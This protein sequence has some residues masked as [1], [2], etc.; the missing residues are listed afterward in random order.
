VEPDNQNRNTCGNSTARAKVT[1]HGVCGVVKI[2]KMQKPG[3]SVAVLRPS[4]GG[5]VPAHAVSVMRRDWRSFPGARFWFTGTYRSPKLGTLRAPTPLRPATKIGFVFFQRSQSLAHAD[6][7]QRQQIAIGALYI[8]M[9]NGFDKRPP[10]SIVVTQDAFGSGGGAFH[11]Q[12]PG[13]E[14]L[15]A[16]KAAIG[17][18]PI[19]RARSSQ[20]SR[21]FFLAPT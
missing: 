7:R 4:D 1:S 17:R 16:R 8:Y 10:H 21:R 5:Q 12:Q 9:A 11:Q 20:W 3:E 13:S 14:L 2:S 19:R 15:T 18:G 6:G